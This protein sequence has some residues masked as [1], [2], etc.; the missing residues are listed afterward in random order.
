LTKLNDAEILAWSD[1]HDDVLWG[2]TMEEIPE[3]TMT[4]LDQSRQRLQEMMERVDPWWKLT[5][6]PDQV[7]NEFSE[8]LQNALDEKD[9]LLAESTIYHDKFKSKISKILEEIDKSWS[10]DVRNCIISGTKKTLIDKEVVAKSLDEQEI[11]H[12]NKTASYIRQELYLLGREYIDRFA[13]SLVEA[14]NEIL[15]EM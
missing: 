2:N 11:L 13:S 3:L 5:V 4:T 9:A 1:W 10:E 7:Y 6:I 14:I 8:S 12:D 15:E